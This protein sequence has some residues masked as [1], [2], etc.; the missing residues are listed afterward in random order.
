[1]ALPFAT[2]ARSRPPRR[3]GAAIHLAVAAALGALLLL[4]AAP[5]TACY[6][7]VVGRGAST[8]GAVL[9]GHNEQNG[10]TQ[11]PNLRVIPPLSR[12]PGAEI[13]LRSGGRLPEAPQTHGFIWSELPG[14]EFS[15]AYM[16]EWGVAVVSD[17]C[18]TREYRNDLTDGGIGYLLRRLVVQRARTAREGVHLAGQLVEQV[19]YSASGRTLVIA[20]PRE[21]W[22]VSLVKGRHWVARRVPD[23]GVVLLPNVHIITEVDL[24]DTLNYLGS[25]DVIDYAVERGWY[26]PDNGQPFS[27]RAAYNTSDG[28]DARQRQG[29]RLILGV[30]SPPLV[31][32]QLP[33]AI[34]PERRLGVEDVIAVLR[35]HGS[36][37]ALCSVNTQEGSVFELRADLPPAVGCVYWRA[38]AEPCTGFLVPWYAGITRTP[39]EYFR[40]VALPEVL[41][42][43]HHFSA[44]EA[45]TGAAWWISFRL[46]NAVN[47]APAAARDSVRIVQSVFERALLDAQPA[48]EA[49]ALNLNA[50]DPSAARDYLTRYSADV[51][52]RALTLSAQMRVAIQSAGPMP[53]AVAGPPSSTRDQAAVPAALALGAAY[54][55]PF[56]H[57]VRIPYLLSEPGQVNL[58]IYDLAGQRLRQLVSG[59]SAPGSHVASWDGRDQSG[60]PAATGTYLVRLRTAAGQHSGRILLLR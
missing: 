39:P 59:Y 31:N 35:Y 19:G 51:A 27:F 32:G 43:A 11:Y 2:R 3:T 41:T 47:S 44:S 57:Q 9:L 5:A 23:D 58:V 40:S 24:A 12:D 15:D 38:A 1:M 56:N 6:S 50:S 52:A 53:T 42:V 30:S 28:I 25:P 26:D 36:S 55:N 49:H 22:L 16:N 54:P 29:Q 4:V 48:T 60:C 37:G 21:A 20:G 8:S 33:F 17:G 46:Q 13:L 18:P 14:K 7:V 34:F 45:G 10:G